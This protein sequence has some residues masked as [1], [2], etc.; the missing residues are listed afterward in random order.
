M[1][2]RYLPFSYSETFSEGPHRSEGES[3]TG[4]DG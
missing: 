4:A 1:I 3:V 2:E